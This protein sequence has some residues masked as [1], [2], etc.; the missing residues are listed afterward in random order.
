MRQL[1]RQITRPRPKPSTVPPPHDR[2]AIAAHRGRPFVVM[3][4]RAGPSAWS[5]SGLGPPRPGDRRTC[6]ERWQDFHFEWEGDF[7][8]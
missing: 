6:L 3:R 1:R 8:V 7:P 4:V 5:A 2:R